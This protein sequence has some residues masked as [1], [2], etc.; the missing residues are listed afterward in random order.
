[1]DIDQ[2]IKLVFFDSDGVLIDRR[3]SS[4]QFHKRFSAFLKRNEIDERRADSEWRKIQKRIKKGELNWDNGREI[5]AKKIGLN[6][7]QTQE[8]ER[9]TT[10]AWKFDK[11]SEKNEKQTLLELKASGLKLA[12]LSDTIV[13]SND[14]AALYK[15]LG[16][17]KFFDCFFVCSETRYM[18]PHKKAYMNVLNHFKIKTNEAVFVGH[19]KDEID[20]AKKLGIKT[21]S[22]RENSDGDFSA[23]SF[24]DIQ[25]I[26]QRLSKGNGIR[27]FFVRHGESKMNERNVYQNKNTALSKKGV[28]Q[29]KAVARK[30]KGIGIEAVF[31]SDYRRA[32]QTA[33]L[34]QRQIGKKIAYTNLLGELREPSEMVGVDHDA[35]EAIEMRRIREI[36]ADN[37]KWRY[38][39]GENTHELRERVLKWVQNV[40]K[41]GKGS[42][43]AV[44]HQLVITM[45][46]AIAVFGE[47]VTGKQFYQALRLFRQSNTGITECEIR[48]DGTWKILTFN[49]YS[50]L[51]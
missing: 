25:K 19:S 15:D 20:G 48:E 33:K 45:I 40:R 46:I 47:N 24:E 34:I 43:L 7:N 38:G 39:D 41:S 32:M 51:A 37:K 29:A 31:S 8:Y 17:K 22:Y 13:G 3:N 28:K 27:I 18:K 4:A 6:K 42:V 1:M 12:V 21:I 16:V 49:D 14:L 10:W 11:L 50:H 35:P 23:K 30:L 44:T 36:H 5:E 9:I 2:M 26:I